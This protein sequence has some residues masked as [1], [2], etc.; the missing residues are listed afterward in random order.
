[1]C[2]AV[3]KDYSGHKPVQV[4]GYPVCI[5]NPDAMMGYGGD[6]HSSATIGNK[7]L[8]EN[9]RDI[10]LCKCVINN[11]ECQVPFS[12]I[13]R[14]YLRTLHYCEDINMM[15]DSAVEVV[16][17]KYYH[18]KMF[19]AFDEKI[20]GKCKECGK[21][22]LKTLMFGEYCV[23]HC[24]RES[25]GIGELAEAWSNGQIAI[26]LD[27]NNN[28]NLIILL[29]EHCPGIV[30]KSG[31]SLNNFVPN[32]NKVLIVKDGKAMTASPEFV[33]VTTVR[34]EEFFASNSE[35]KKVINR[36]TK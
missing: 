10:F 22:F 23:E 34:S 29:H 8:T 18:I 11:K 27:G 17:D 33:K 32:G 26:A 16:V 3:I 1:M 19:S 30:W 2:R 35:Q 31:R 13:K 36:R 15:S 6:H 14:S 25:V 5:N 24:P 9:S 12:E 28:K 20:M 7:T 21:V 4:G